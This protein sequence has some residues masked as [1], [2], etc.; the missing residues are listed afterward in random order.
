MS[1]YRRLTAFCTCLLLLAGAFSAL[2]QETVQPAGEE[3][4]MTAEEAEAAGIEVEGLATKGLILVVYSG[5]RPSM[6]A[7]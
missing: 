6:L 5:V 2:A 4:V 3:A 1:L 7:G